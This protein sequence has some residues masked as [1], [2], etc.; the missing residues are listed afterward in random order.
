LSIYLLNEGRPEQRQ[1][2][3]VLRPRGAAATGAAL[4]VGGRRTDLE[5]ENF[6]AGSLKII[7]AADYFHC[8]VIKFYLKTFLY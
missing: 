4:E 6:E 7:L 8:L 5:A 1:L 3:G 2:V